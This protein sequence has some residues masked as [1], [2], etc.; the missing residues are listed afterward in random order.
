[1]FELPG[2]DPKT[3]SDEELLTRSGEIARKMNWAYRFGSVEAVGQMQRI[4]ATIDAERRERAFMSRWEDIAEIISAPIET[5][6]DLREQAHSA[7]KKR[8]EAREA[9]SRHRQRLGNRRPL[10]VPSPTPV[11]QP[12]APGDK[13]EDAPKE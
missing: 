12:P 5:D 2:F 8:E 1:M 6:P 13:P 10:P 4:L 7:E 11:S 3:M 9:E